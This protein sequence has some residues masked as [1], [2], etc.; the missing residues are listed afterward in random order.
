[1]ITRLTHNPLGN[2]MVKSFLLILFVV[3]LSVMDVEGQ[4]AWEYSLL[5]LDFSFNNWIAKTCIALSYFLS[6]SLLLRIN[7]KH[8]FVEFDSTPF[9]F[10]VTVGFLLAPLDIMYVNV[11]FAMLLNVL[12]LSVLLRIYHQPVVGSLIFASASLIS[13]ASILFYPSIIFVLL[14]IATLITF[15]PF[16]LK[17]YLL[18]IVG[19]LLPLFY[20]F[21]IEYLTN[22]NWVSAMVAIP[23]TDVW[24]QSFNQLSVLFPCFL[25]LFVFSLFKVIS[26]QSKFIVR[27][28]NQ[29][30][31][32]F[33]FIALSFI[34]SRIVGIENVLF[35]LLLPVGLFYNYWY[36]FVNRKWI[37]DTVLLVFTVA[38]FFVK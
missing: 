22:N 32:L 27:Q 31:I 7:S 18:M 23:T 19:F 17:D 36:Q 12:G 25:P 11:A 1:M 16:N 26:Y 4:G 14:V 13:I 35:F 6:T 37:L 29:L 38:S 33:L 9:W 15:R 2:F 10:F 3:K 8:R 28:R 34:V 30:I 20:L 5:K 21:G 24:F